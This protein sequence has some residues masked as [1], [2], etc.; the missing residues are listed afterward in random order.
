MDAPGTGRPVWSVNVPE[1]R[2]EPTYSDGP[3]SMSRDV[4]SRLAGLVVSFEVLDVAGEVGAGRPPVQAAPKSKSG[5]RISRRFTST[6]SIG[7]ACR[8]R[9]WLP[10][11]RARL[12]DAP[13][14]PP[15]RAWNG[16][17]ASPGDFGRASARSEG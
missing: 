8:D 1:A 3:T 17:R 2:K 5:I 6:L 10:I 14:R 11:R 13:R 4:V 7:S 12:H 16:R 9:L 15:L